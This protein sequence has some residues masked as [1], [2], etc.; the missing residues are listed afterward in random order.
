MATLGSGTITV[1]RKVDTPTLFSTSF[2][3]SAFDFQTGD[4]LELELSGGGSVRVYWD[5]SYNDSRMEVG[6]IVPEAALALVPVGLA[7]PWLL[8]KVRKGRPQIQ[9]IQRGNH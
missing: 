9:K 6:T 4:R 7:I 2:S 5:G 1:P 8:K 3:H